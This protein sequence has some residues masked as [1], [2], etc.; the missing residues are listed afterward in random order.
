M[1]GGEFN[2]QSSVTSMYRWAT[3]LHSELPYRFGRGRAMPAW[4]FFFEVTRR[5]NLRCKM[6]QYID[7][8]ETVPT[9][10][11][12]D[13]ELTT[14]EWLSVIDQTPPWAFITFTG[15]EVFVRKD[16]MQIL[17]HACKKRRVH[18]ISNAT[19]LT[20]ERAKRL[21]EIAPKRLGGKGFNFIG[22]SLDGI[23][24]IHDEIRAQRGAFEKSTR[25]VRMLTEFRRQ[26]GKKTPLVHINFVLQD[27][28]M[29]CLPDMPALVKDMG[30]D[31]LNLLTETRA[32][33]IEQLGHEDPGKWSREDMRP[34]SQIRREKMDYALRKCKEEANRHGIELRFPRMP[35]DEVLKHYGEGYEMN[36]FD[37]R[38]IWS[39]LFVGAKGG[40]YP[41]WIYKAGNVR[42]TPLRKLWNTAGMRDFRSRRKDAAFAVCNGCCEM[43]H[44]TY[45][46]DGD[47]RIPAVD[48]AMPGAPDSQQ[49]SP[50]PERQPEVVGK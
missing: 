41:C 2:T 30:A 44:K 27:E 34:V 47:A 17:E 26:A 25:G 23:G 40:V 43:E 10:M 48:P 11:Q 15:G 12:A 6:C 19:M 32:H 39:N 24:D 4:H 29:D 33:D 9:K 46:K 7:W 22:V 13:N 35:Y 18:M 36:D 16:F 21:V 37:C 20:E 45:H 50:T 14:E 49:P 42:D 3:R 8:L 38:A 5:C 1:N 31:I 28:N